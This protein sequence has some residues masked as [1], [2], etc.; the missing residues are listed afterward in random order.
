M[1]T[2]GDLLESEQLRAREYFH[3][4]EHPVAGRWTYPGPPV[5]MGGVEWEEGRAPLLGEHN[6][7]VYRGELGLAAEELARLRAAG[8]V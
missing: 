3:E 1:H 6:D 7:E 4:I 2:L 5:R 8:V